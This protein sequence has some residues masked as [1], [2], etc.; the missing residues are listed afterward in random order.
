M[1]EERPAAL[2]GVSLEQSI[3]LI[4]RRCA[5]MRMDRPLD[6]RG[7]R[8]GDPAACFSILRFLFA[9]FSQALSTYLQSRGHSFPEGLTDEQFGA[10]IIACWPLLS[11]HALSVSP[12]RLASHGWGAHRLVFT[13]QCLFVCAEKHNELQSAARGEQSPTVQQTDELGST[14]ERMI[15]AYRQALLES[16]AA[17]DGQAEQAM[18]VAAFH[19]GLG[20]APAEDE[21]Q[22]DAEGEQIIQEQLKRAGLSPLVETS[23]PS[24]AD[25]YGAEMEALDMGEVDQ[26]EQEDGFDETLLNT[27]F[28]S[29]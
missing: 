23:C 27:P 15:G 6:P 25:K 8:A 17:V 20:D 12:Q 3:S 7:L 1:A 13:L 29:D 28:I 24:D 10:R 9:R 14:L 2:W 16:E 18:W 21:P 22:K 11:P 4:S 5:L 19:S 26:V